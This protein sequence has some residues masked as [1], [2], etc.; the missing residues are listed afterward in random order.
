MLCRECKVCGTVH[1]KVSRVSRHCAL[2][3]VPKLSGLRCANFVKLWDVV[4]CV[5]LKTWRQFPSPNVHSLT[6]FVLCRD[7]TSFDL[8]SCLPIEKPNSRFENFVHESVQLGS[9]ATVSAGCVVGKGSVLGDKCSV[10]RSI[11]GTTCKLGNS[12]KIVSSIVM[13]DVIVEEGSHIQN[14][15]ICSGSHLQVCLS[16]AQALHFV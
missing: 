12:V 14:S 4:L 5:T 16:C 9:K 2:P 15:I 1:C 10:K 13:D 11:I 8:A 7:L 3:N 6:A